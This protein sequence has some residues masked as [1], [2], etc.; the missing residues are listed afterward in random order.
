MEP[1]V[2]NKF[3]GIIIFPYKK[4]GSYN[5]K[6]PSEFDKTFIITW[7]VSGDV[8][9]ATAPTATEPLPQ[10][11]RSLNFNKITCN[12]SGEMVPGDKIEVSQLNADIIQ[13]LL[14]VAMKDNLNDADA[15]HM[16]DQVFQFANSLRVHV[17]GA[18]GVGNILEGGTSLSNASNKKQNSNKNQTRRRWK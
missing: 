16:V 9:N 1:T 6:Q 13:F 5:C 7:N 11:T 2:F 17:S 10:Q 8:I 14:T 3:T 12:K 18:S 4:D 15:R